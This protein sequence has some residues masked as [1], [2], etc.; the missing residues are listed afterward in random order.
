MTWLRL[1]TYVFYSR[2][3]G[4][5][6]KWYCWLCGRLV[7]FYV[8]YFFI[9]KKLYRVRS[10]PMANNAWMM[11]RWNKPTIIY[12]SQTIFGQFFLSNQNGWQV[13]VKV[14]RILFLSLQWEMSSCSKTENVQKILFQHNYVIWGF[15]YKACFL[16]IFPVNCSSLSYLFHPIIYPTMSEKHAIWDWFKM[17]NFKCYYSTATAYNI[18]EVIPKRKVHSQN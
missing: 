4:S 9:P 2:T 3:I 16:C 7:Y 10:T 11:E 14:I 15:F 1:Y 18:I 12:I 13:H 5:F 17:S 6:W 8:H